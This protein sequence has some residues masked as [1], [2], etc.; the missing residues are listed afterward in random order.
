MEDLKPRYQ[1][2]Q[3]TVMKK[4]ETG[5]D[6]DADELLSLLYMIKTVSKLIIITMLQKDIGNWIIQTHSASPRN[7]L[8]RIET[9]LLE[10]HTFIKL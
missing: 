4:D 3:L 6:G 5:K 1:I 10:Y 8:H 9:I 7:K 2:I